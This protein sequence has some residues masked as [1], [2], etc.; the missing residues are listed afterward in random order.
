M[1][2][3]TC[4]LSTPP[5]FILVDGNMTPKWAYPSLAVIKGDSLCHSISAASILAKEWRDNLMDEYDLQYPGYGFSK[6]K[7]YGTKMHL[8]AIS[9]LGPCQI[10]RKSFEPIKSLVQ[11]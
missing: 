5:D 10:H 2:K 4:A 7:G 6:H 11:L 9:R 1:Q 3:A 8:E